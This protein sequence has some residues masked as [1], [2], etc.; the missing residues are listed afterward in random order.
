MKNRKMKTVSVITIA[1]VAL[2]IGGVALF[3]KAAGPIGPR[4][5]VSR[6][7]AAAP[8]P[9]AMSLGLPSEDTAKTV[10]DASL[11]YHH[12]QWVDVPMGSAKIH[13][14]VIYPAKCCPY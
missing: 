8:A 3:V 6:A 13:T 14:F 5:R 2:S 1:V 10:L 7:S 9:A 11:P 12:P 4:G